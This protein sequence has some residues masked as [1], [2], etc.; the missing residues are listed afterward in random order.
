MQPAPLLNHSYFEEF[1]PNIP[2]L[3]PIQQLVTIVLSTVYPKKPLHPDSAHSPPFAWWQTAFRS[4]HTCI[5]FARWATAVSFP[6]H[7]LHLQH[8]V[9]SVA[10][11]Q[12]LCSLPSCLGA[13]CSTTEPDSQVLSR[14]TMSS[15]TMMGCALAAPYVFPLS[16]PPAWQMV[17]LLAS[18]WN[19]SPDQWLLQILLIMHFVTLS[20]CFFFKYSFQ[21]LKIK[22]IV[23]VTKANPKSRRSPK[24]FPLIR[25]FLQCFLLVSP[26][27]YG[28]VFCLLFFSFPWMY[29]C[30]FLTL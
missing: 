29:M 7:T 15:P 22:N 27:R 26:L 1:P 30:V 5:A 25:I 16:N 2:F 4:L 18:Q 14:G 8:P 23:Y 3:F 17:A 19:G 11:L 21:I 10:L 24:Y 12:T 28:N 9:T 6:P 13:A 20:R